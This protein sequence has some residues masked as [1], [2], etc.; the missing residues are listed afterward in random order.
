MESGSVWVNKHADLRPDL[1]FGGAKFSG[2]GSE[3]GEEGLKEF[4]Q[5]QVLNMAR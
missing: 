5:V 4:T 1:P 3:L 2:V